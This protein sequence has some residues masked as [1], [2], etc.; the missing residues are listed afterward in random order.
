MD[1]ATVV[2][3][4]GFAVTFFATTHFLLPLAFGISSLALC[5][6][7]P[8]VSKYPQ[9]ASLES[10]ARSIKT[11]DQQLIQKVKQLETNN[12]TLREQV[13]LLADNNDDFQ[14]KL[15]HFDAVNQELQTMTTRL[16][17]TQEQLKKV[18]EDLAR[19]TEKLGKCRSEIH[20]HVEK[21]GAHVGAVTVQYNPTQP[22]QL[23]QEP[24]MMKG[25]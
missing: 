25:D 11:T 16:E 1:L 20:S 8:Y 9:L 6:A 10:S 3:I 2:S 17:I 13:H 4:I 7:A 23:M 15:D 22:L 12:Q 14:K 18:Q 19:E 21:L 5:F 24:T